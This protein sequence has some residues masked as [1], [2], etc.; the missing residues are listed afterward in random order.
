MAAA[1]EDIV[2]FEPDGRSLLTVRVTCAWSAEKQAFD[3][4]WE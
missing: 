1:L 3:P 4:K 2:V